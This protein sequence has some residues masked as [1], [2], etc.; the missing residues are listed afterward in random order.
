[1]LPSRGTGLASE[2]TRM[3]GLS[4]DVVAIL[5]PSFEDKI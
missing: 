1:M 4:V 2:S 3:T 5:E